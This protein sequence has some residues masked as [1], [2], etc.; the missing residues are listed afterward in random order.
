MKKSGEYESESNRYGSD[1]R[2]PIPENGRETYRADGREPGR[3]TGRSGAGE[4]AQRPYSPHVLLVHKNESK[5]EIRKHRLHRH[6][7]GYLTRHKIKR[8]LIGIV[9]Y[10]LFALGLGMV[11]MGVFSWVENESVVSIFI[12]ARDL[13]SFDLLHGFSTDGKPAETE[14]KE[15]ASKE[16]GMLIP[17]FYYTAE[18]IGTVK[19]DSASVDVKLYQGDSESSLKLGAGHST[20]SYL[21]GQGHN[22]VFAGHR[23]S[24]FKPL[25]NVKVGDTVAVQTTYGEFTYT[26]REIKILEK[27][28]FGE[29]T[30]DNGVE[31]LTLYTCY[32]F[33]YIGNAP[34]RYAVFC[35]LKEAVL[36]S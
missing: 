2:E 21:P 34:D 31:Q 32:P 25:E 27:D 11:S 8:S 26:V 1:V 33:I 18:Q 13:P 29:I 28:S 10:L 9:P 20:S 12:T 3:E 24:Y 36:N 6:R 15:T 19:I 14:T 4:T 23:T 16:E 17:P 35:D 22:V 30:K 7:H 5:G